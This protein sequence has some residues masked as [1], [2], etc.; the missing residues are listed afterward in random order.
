[1]CFIC[2]G[3]YKAQVPFLMYKHVHISKRLMCILNSELERGLKM[4]IIYEDKT[5]LLNRLKKVLFSKK[6]NPVCVYYHFFLW[7]F[8][9][10]VSKSKQ[11]ISSQMY[12]VSD[13]ADMSRS[14]ML[15]ERYFITSH[16]FTVWKHH[17]PSVTWRARHMFTLSGDC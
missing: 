9:S 6:R 11:L 13:T 1:M 10:F 3:P 12:R 16:S 7:T 8:L 17:I 14:Y 2:M 4:C 5:I 15:T